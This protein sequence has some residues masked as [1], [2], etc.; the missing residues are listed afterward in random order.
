M[1][2]IKLLVQNFLV[3]GLGGVISKIIPL[4]MVPIVTRIMPNS[5]Y[6]GI[7]DMSGTIVSFASALAILGMIDAM[8]RMFFE[9]DDEI[10]KMQVCSTTFIFTMIMSSIV[11]IIMIFMR[12]WI[13]RIF[14][15]HEKYAY[16]VYLSAM[17]VLVG[18]PSG[19]LSTPTRMQNKR[20]VFLVTNTVGPILAYSVSIPM[21]LK[22]YYVIALPLAGLISS[23]FMGITFWL[24]NKKWFDIRLFDKNILKDLLKIGIPLFPSFLIYWIFNSCD[25]VMITNIIGLEAAG[26]YSVGAKL[27]NCSQLI[28][29][30]FAGGWQYFSFST[31]RERNQV[32]TNSMIFEYLGII[33]FSIS[34]L[35]CAVSSELF[36]ILF[37]KEYY[38]GYV[39]TPYL[40]LAPLLQMLY[41]V[42]ANQFVV[43]KKT[44][45][46]FFIL[47][48]G[49][50]FNIIINLFFIP[51]LDIEGAAIATLMGYVIADII[52]VTVLLKMKLMEINVKFIVATFITV[53][54]IVCWRMF[55]SE[56]ILSGLMSAF[57]AILGISFLYLEDIKKIINALKKCLVKKQHNFMNEKP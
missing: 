44:W 23:I 50:V 15:E 2:K 51:A 22:G 40:F 35:V 41:Q 29:T 16:V 34:M 10:Y 28:Y 5:S 54:Y 21:L 45:P 39:L 3:Y 6:F 32:K 20:K 14:F 18:A 30:A 8:Y 17:S 57:V 19:V 9:K 37:E 12:N 7:S 38:M 48:S 36:S 49:A 52:C 42:A 46:S 55:F 25:R 27:G 13:S 33:S 1:T 56:K 4:L 31:M 11:F 53:G 47:S 43:I 26:I 24:I